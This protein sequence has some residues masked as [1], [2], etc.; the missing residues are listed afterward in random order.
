MIV[1]VDELIKLNA[2]YMIECKLRQLIEK[3]RT[4]FANP[5]VMI[6]FNSSST[7]L[8]TCLN[9]WRINV[10]NIFNN[11]S[12]VELNIF[13]H[14]I[15]LYFYD[16]CNIQECMTFCKHLEIHVEHSGIFLS[17]IGPYDDLYLVESIPLLSN[18]R[19]RPPHSYNYCAYNCREKS[20]VY[21][22]FNNSKRI[23]MS[24]K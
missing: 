18:A 16:K 9:W 3:K 22:S 14:T 6:H 24:T 23:L 10:S 11:L 8:T 1:I 13:S 19:N 15:W 21:K 20:D 4:R 5:H 12:R 7:K 2:N 17:P